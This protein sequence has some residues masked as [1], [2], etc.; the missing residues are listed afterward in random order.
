MIMRG[1]FRRPSFG[2]AEGFGLIGL[3]EDEEG[4]LLLALLGD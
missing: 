4:L 3:L 2:F 1:Q